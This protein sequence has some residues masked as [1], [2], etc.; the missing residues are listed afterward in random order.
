MRG[1]KALSNV[2][3]SLTL[4]IVTSLAGFII[5]KLLISAYGSSI[6][7]LI[8]SIKSFM[9]YLNLV[10]TG[11]GTSTIVALYSPLALKDKG[12]INGIL[13]AAQRFYNHAGVLLTGLIVVLATV[14]PHIVKHSVS[15]STASLMVIIIG[16]SSLSHYFLMGKNRVL[17]TADQRSFVIS[18]NQAAA[19]ILSTTACVFLILFRVHIV[20]IQGVITIIY[21]AQAITL[22][23]YVRKNYPFLEKCVAPSSGA[24]DKRWDAML[25]QL[26]FVLTS[27]SPIVLITIICGLSE[28]SVYAVYYMII[29]AV[30]ML[31]S[32]CSNG[33]TAGFGELI[34]KE[35][36]DRVEKAF[37]SYEHLFFII[38]TWV[39]TCT[40]ILYIP[41][42]NVYVQGFKDAN[43]FR[44]SFVILMVITGF[45][46][47]MRFPYLT[48]V[49][50]AGKFKETRV[51][52][53]IEPCII[54][55]AGTVFANL[56]GVQGILVAM[57]IASLYRT[58]DLAIYF[59]RHIGRRSVGVIIAK[60]ALNATCAVMA[61]L[62]FIVGFVL[63]KASDLKLWCIYAGLVAIW[64][65]GIVLIGNYLFYRLVTVQCVLRLTNI[66]SKRSF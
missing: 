7:G 40:A 2:T 17:L 8:A 35:N 66:I 11:I 31:I 22:T 46:Y 51:G 55:S 9:Y 60:V 36:T 49:N 29:A 15:A 1:K 21:T 64:T 34:M 65:L 61:G 27:N 30:T 53:I 56:F 48:M 45:L 50:A 25:H 18:L 38:L 54:I 28:V 4:Q 23:L 39:Y 32:S 52:A 58:V 19:V 47:C 10:E 5:P 41:F 33:M 13:A 20:V 59:S 63:V 24:G 42:I 14:Y 16:V 37:A 62:P 57:G 6:N 43:Y 26:G 44:P 3:A 12:A